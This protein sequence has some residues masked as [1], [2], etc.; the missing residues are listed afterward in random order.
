MGKENF[1]RNFFWRDQVKIIEDQ[2]LYL[3]MF[4]KTILLQKI[5]FQLLGHQMEYIQIFKKC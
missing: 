4:S 3:K 1:N 5:I 2:S